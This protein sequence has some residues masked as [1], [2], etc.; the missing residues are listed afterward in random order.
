MKRLLPAVLAAALA[1][2]ALPA[3]AETLLTGFAG[4]ASMKLPMSVSTSLSV[5][6]PEPLERP[7]KSGVVAN[8][9]SKPNTPF[10]G[11]KPSAPP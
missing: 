2:S 4:V 5:K 11:R 10:L 6:T 3:R 8:S 9:A 1:T 7:K